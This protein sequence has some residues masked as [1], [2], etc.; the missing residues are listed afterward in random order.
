M[1]LEALLNDSDNYSRV[2]R[3]H[4]NISLCLP[5]VL[6]QLSP[7]KWDHFAW[8]K[9]SDLYTIPLTC[10]PFCHRSTYPGCVSRQPANSIMYLYSYSRKNLKNYWKICTVKNIY[11]YIFTVFYLLKMYV[12]GYIFNDTLTYLCIF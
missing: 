7:P 9:Y 1:S 4:I 11:I 3:G 6:D 8:P 2:L 10:H 12:S 5:E